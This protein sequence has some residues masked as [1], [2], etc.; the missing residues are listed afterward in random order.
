M[1]KEI[2]YSF[3]QWC[4]DNNHLDYLDLWDYE[5]NDCSPDSVSY[6]TKEKY[7]FKCSRNI[8]LSEQKSISNITHGMDVVCQRC[9]SFAQWCIDNDHEDFLD[10]WDYNLN[11]ISPWD[12]KTTSQMRCY[13]KCPKQLHVSELKQIGAITQYSV[14]KCNQCDSLGQWMIDN[15]GSDAIAK[16]WSDKNAISPFFVARTAKLVKYYFK[17]GTGEHPDYEMTPGNFHKGCRCPVCSHTKVVSGINDVATTHPNCVKYFKNPED[18]TM[19]SACSKVECDFICPECG[20]ERRLPIVVLTQF[21]FS[22]KVCGDGISYPNKFMR[23][24]L[25]QLSQRQNK[26]FKFE[27]EKTFEWSRDIICNNIKLNGTKK[28]DFFIQT[29]CQIII[30]CHGGQHY[31]KSQKSVFGKKRTLQDEQENDE[32]K[33]GLAINNGISQGNYVV[34]DCSESNAEFIKASI[35]KSSLPALLDFSINDIDWTLC[36]RYCCTSLVRLVCDKWN[37]GNYNIT[38]LSNDLGLH[39]GTVRRY[40]QR[41]ANSKFCNYPNMI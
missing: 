25:Q 39:R 9:K 35:M 19:Y 2:K 29:E 24:L 17:C 4:I 5:L 37:S 33:M 22:C 41:G 34:L 26:S 38:Q 28:Y 27:S 32:I 16:Y 15:L 3:K 6:S 7:Y 36:D 13:F 21:G 14:L 31:Y 18:A 23:A 12:V 11:S 20:S 8:H 40:L 10:L 30:E 1:K